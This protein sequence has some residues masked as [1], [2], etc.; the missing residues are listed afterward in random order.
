M[1]ADLKLVTK[2]LAREDPAPM[3]D[4]LA[5]Y[6]WVPRMT[7][8]AR[9]NR[10]GTLGTYVHPC[11]VDARCLEL[12]GIDAKRFGDIAVASTTGHELL[13]GLATAGVRSAEDAWF[14]PLALEDALQRGE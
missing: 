11:P 6:A 14:D 8:K 9:A 5:G 10:A 13:A 7:D 4:T 12:L 2:D 1:N 3:D